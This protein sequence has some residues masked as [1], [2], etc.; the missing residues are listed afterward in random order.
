MKAL[1]F[2]GTLTALPSGM[3]NLTDITSSEK[4]LI[5]DKIFCLYK[6]R[7]RALEGPNPNVMDVIPETRVTWTEIRNFLL[8]AGFEYYVIDVYPMFNKYAS[9]CARRLL[10]ES[11]KKAPD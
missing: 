9:K 3:K 4:R 6:S 11:S 10:R 5:E 1:P 8:E 7:T 2:F